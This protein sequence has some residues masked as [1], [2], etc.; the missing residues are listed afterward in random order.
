[1][2]NTDWDQHFHLA[3]CKSLTR[4][5]S[6]HCPIV[7][8][9][10]DERLN[11]PHIFRFEMAWLTQSGFREVIK[12]KWPD[13]GN[14]EV[15][16]YW[17]MVKTNIRRFCRGWGRNINTQ[18]K[19][20]KIELLNQLQLLDIEA[21]GG[22]FSADKWQERYEIEEKLEEIYTFEEILWQKRG[23]LKWILKGDANNAFFHGIAS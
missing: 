17:K 15:Q 20:D 13:R 10:A 9:T 21:E 8:N 14:R 1:M 23:G 3:T 22:G 5:G 6:D 4:V 12:S 11:Q 18:K 16:D 19:K 2:C 7:V